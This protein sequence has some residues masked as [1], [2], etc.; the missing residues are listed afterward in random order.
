MNSWS[1]FVHILTVCQTLDDSWLL[2][3]YHTMYVCAIP[4]L[5][6]ILSY[7]TALWQ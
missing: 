3:N 1:V 7:G 2:G 6:H 5:C 4:Q